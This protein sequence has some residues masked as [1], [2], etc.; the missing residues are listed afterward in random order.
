MPR[1]NT[2]RTDVSRRT[3]GECETCSNLRQSSAYHGNVRRKC[4]ICGEIHLNFNIRVGYSE[5]ESVL[6]CS[7]CWDTSS[8]TD[9]ISPSR[10]PQ[11][12]C[13][14]CGDVTISRYGSSNYCDDC[15][16]DRELFCCDRCGNE[17]YDSGAN[18]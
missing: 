4:E 13:E 7:Y 6:M 17:H 3:G 10:I 9:N 14:G 5:G 11:K 16:D 1:C 15:C 18:A 2:C 12:D 8:S